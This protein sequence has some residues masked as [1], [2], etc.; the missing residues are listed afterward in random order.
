[1]YYDMNTCG[2][3]V[4]G[5]SVIPFLLIFGIV[6]VDKSSFEG[7]ILTSYWQRFLEMFTEWPKTKWL[8]FNYVIFHLYKFF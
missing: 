2:S 1:M 7:F 4:L 6:H 8:N 3:P 5:K